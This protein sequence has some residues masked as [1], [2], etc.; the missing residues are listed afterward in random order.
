MEEANAELL[1]KFLFSCRNRDKL[2][3]K[4]YLDPTIQKV[5]KKAQNDNLCGKNY[6][7][8]RNSTSNLTVRRKQKPSTV[9][10]EIILKY[11]NMLDIF[12]VREQFY[13][14]I[15]ELIIQKDN[16]N[17]IKVYTQNSLSGVD[18]DNYLGILQIANL[19]LYNKIMTDSEAQGDLLST[20]KLKLN[21]HELS[22]ILRKQDGG[23]FRK[24]VLQTVR[25]MSRLYFEYKKVIDKEGNYVEGGS[26]F[27]SWHGER[28]HSHAVKE[29]KEITIGINP[30]A[31]Y[32]MK[33]CRYNYC[34]INIQE[35]FKLPTVQLRLIYFH[36][37]RKV[38]PGLNNFLT[39]YVEDLAKVLW[40]T[41]TNKHTNK[42]RKKRIRQICKDLYQ[43]QS[44]LTDFEIT[45]VQE[46][47]SIQAI[48]VKRRKGLIEHSS[49]DANLNVSP[50][51]LDSSLPS[52]DEVPF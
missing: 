23:K 19:K 37:C 24:D 6:T 21:F 31:W 3:R 47:S 4:S 12:T 36:L 26:N 5:I 25:K 32:I 15:Q 9:R 52:L 45:L 49:A 48:R 7:P 20:V 22:K 16:D 44:S 39:F 18:L 35:R 29:I 27:L 43:L 14:N 8:L 33:N 28:D 42:T 41:T 51:P 13:P 50:E 2:N 11:C 34:L 17:W 46:K 1:Q 40:G 30:F 38:V 10:K